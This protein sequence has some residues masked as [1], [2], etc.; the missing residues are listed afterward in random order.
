MPTLVTIPFSHFCEK[1]RWALDYARITYR[2]E[3]HLPIFH[4]LAV[5]RACG[6][7]GSVPVLVVEG[8]RALDDSPLII[9]W[10]DARAPAGRKLL[11]SDG[12]SRDEAIALERHLDVDLAPDVRRFAYFHLLSNRAATLELMKIDT[13]R[14][15]YAAL[16]AGFPLVRQLM[17]RAMRIDAEHTARSFDRI[18][19]VFD[20]INKRLSDGRP[21][22]MGDRLGVVDIAFAAFASPLFA[23]SEHPVRG[24]ARAPRAPALLAE[25]APLRE[26]PAGIFALRMYRDHRSIHDA[27]RSPAEEQAQV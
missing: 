14:L 3:G 22:L 13:P 26:T 25:V 8:E 6:K 18:R 21:Y 1:A 19:A 4:R 16:R 5:K 24:R 7:A 2:E 17:R 15:Q 20:E 27:R 23:P 10:A 9:R 11:P 12:A